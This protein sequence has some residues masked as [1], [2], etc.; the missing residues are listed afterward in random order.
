MGPQEVDLASTSKKR[1]RGEKIFIGV[2]I[3]VAASMIIAPILTILFTQQ[4]QPLP[5]P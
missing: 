1:T 2:G 4:P 5:V 3:L